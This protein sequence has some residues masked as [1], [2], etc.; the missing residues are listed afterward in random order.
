MQLRLAV[1]TVAVASLLAGI[2]QTLASNNAVKIAVLNDQ[3]S[4]FSSASGRDSVTAV[5]LAVQ[6]FG[7]KVLG[8]PIE[9]VFADH[10]NKPDVG[11]TIARQWLDNE[12]VDVI[13]DLANSAVAL[14]VNTL[15]G[16]KK[17]IGLFV[18]PITDKITEENCNGH[19]LAW[20]YNPYSVAH[21][22]AKA[23]IDAGRTTFFILSADYEAGK[24]QEEAMKAA[25]EQFG[26][27]TVNAIRAP[28]G[29]TDFSSFLL[30]AQSSGAKVLMLTLTG[31]ELIN[32]VKQVNEYGLVDR[33]MTIGATI[34]FQ[35]EAKAIG[36]DLLRGVQVAAPWAW[37]M[38]DASRA[39]AEKMRKRTGRAPGWAHA[40]SYSATMA[41]LKAVEAAGTDDAEKVLAQL[42]AMKIDDFFA[43]NA[44]LWPNGRLTHDFVLTQVREPSEMKD[45]DDLL[46]VIGRIDA[47]DAFRPIEQSRCPLVKK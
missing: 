40:G 5:E 12:N 32:A 35:S 36:P 7:G 19:V 39:F 29:T 44:K 23:H 14:G 43:R 26:G 8:K 9:V 47:K 22:T 31:S 41:Y 37:S 21:S 11:L 18:S 30:Q 33:G 28:L 4:S 34:L 17:K 10:Q 6:D 42:H 46:K 45:P 24:A 20:A 25:I 15:I 16:E 2:V 38:D 3:S 13:V 27:K 1:S